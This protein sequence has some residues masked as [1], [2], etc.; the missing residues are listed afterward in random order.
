MVVGEGL[1]DGTWH[2]KKRR[3]EHKADGAIFPLDHVILV[4]VIAGTGLFNG[5]TGR[6]DF[7]IISGLDLLFI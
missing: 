4:G 1:I 5:G 7:F 6:A 3:F 2:R